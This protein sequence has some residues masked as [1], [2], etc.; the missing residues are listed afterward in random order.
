MTEKTKVYYL[1]LGIT[2]NELIQLHLLYRI[3]MSQLKT[4]QSTK[5]YECHYHRLLKNVH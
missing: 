3:R 5:I 4:L 1:Q 2:I